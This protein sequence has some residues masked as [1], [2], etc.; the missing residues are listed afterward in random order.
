MNT[1]RPKCRPIAKPTLSP[2]IAAAAAR[3]VSVAM[4]MWPR[5]ASSAAPISA[6]SAGT[7]MP[8][9]SIAIRTK[10]SV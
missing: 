3:I 4:S 8:I 10:T 9:V 1:R 7:G 2:R 6:V 5:C